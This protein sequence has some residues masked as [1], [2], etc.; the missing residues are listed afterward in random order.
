MS[1]TWLVM[2]AML[3]PSVARAEPR[4]LALLVGIND[5]QAVTDLKGC[6]NDVEKMRSVLM[7]RFGFAPADIVLLKDAEASKAAILQTFRRHLIDKALTADTV[8]VFHYSGHGSRMTDTS[9]DEREDGMDET[10]V[11]QDSRQGSVLDITD[12]ELNVL[13]RDLTGRTRNVTVILDSC[14]SGSA[15]RGG[16]VARRVPDLVLPGPVAAPAARSGEGASEMR[17][18]GA[19][20]VLISGSAPQELSNEFYKNGQPQGA[21]TYYLTQALENLEGET[22][23]RDLFDLVAP[24]V[25][26]DFPSQHPQIEGARADT[27]LFGEQAV[28]S[29]PHYRV[30][31]PQDR[32]VIGG[33][34]IHGLT[35][36]STLDVYASTVRVFQAPNQPIASVELTRVDAF[37]S[38]AKVLPAGSTPPPVG[39]RAVLRAANLPPARLRVHY[40]KWQAD[41]PHACSGASAMLDDVRQKAAAKGVVEEVSTEAE[42]QIIVEEKGGQVRLLS[43]DLTEVSAPVAANASAVVDK[44]YGWAK[45]HALLALAN[46][47]TRLPVAIEVHH[48]GQAVTS[49]L[50][51]EQVD[52]TVRNGSTVPLYLTLLDLSTDGSVSVLAN[53]VGGAAHSPGASLQTPIQFH[54]PTGRTSVTDTLKVL[55]TTAPIDASVFEQ[56]AVRATALS[57]PPGPLALAFKEAFEGTRSASA[58]TQSEWVTVSAAPIQVGAARAVP[59]G[60]DA[61]AVHVAEGT[62]GLDDATR[63]AFGDCAATPTDCWEPEALG[64]PGTF[65]F[66]PRG[67]R[68]AEAGVPSVGE[69]WEAAYQLR[70]KINAVRVEP[71]T[72]VDSTP[73]NEEE[74][75]GTRS[76]RSRPDKPRAAADSAWSLKHIGAEQAWKLLRDKGAADGEEAK[77]IIVGHPDTGYRKHP[78][79]WNADPAKT[80]ILADDGYDFLDRDN[81]ATDELDQGGFIPNPGHGTKSGS[82]IVSPKGRQMAGEPA[83]QFVSGVA[84]GARLVPLR[85]HRSVV[86]FKTGNLAKA[87]AAAAGDDRSLVKKQADVISIS[88][89]GLPGWALWKAVRLAR[90]KGVIVVAAAGNEVKTV[91]WPAR[92]KEVVAV[93]ASNVECGLWAG[94][95]HGGAVDITAPGESVWRAA[96]D[97]QG[98]DSIGMGQ[99]T[100][101]A[102]AT[103]AGVAALWLAYHRGDLDALKRD[104]K[105][106][107]AFMDALKWKPWRPDDPQSAPSGVTCASHA[108]WQP[109]KYGAGIVNAENVL[110]APLTGGSRGEEAPRSLEDLPLFES[111]FAEGMDLATVKRRYAQLFGRTDA[112]ATTAT[113]GELE[114]EIVNSYATNA[115]VAAALDAFVAAGT[116]A[117]ATAA[118]NALLGADISPTLRGALAAVPAVG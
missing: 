82:V 47:N 118:R 94:A 102:T 55:A 21:L 22:T 62:R 78:E 18:D 108:P 105:V 114:G 57:P 66:R 45:W 8:V 87:I 41:Q 9:G 29:A 49:V 106:T 4:R 48:N 95:S 88:M 16:G 38:Q 7:T 76:G 35:V 60:V 23:Y 36:G 51:E 96:M 110:K 6:V 97:P 80:T 26:A 58:V 98:I 72:E 71:L 81:D 91:V 68:S 52:I 15:T 103:V 40:C 112:D 116:P 107:D 73:W 69:A 46:Q 63:G 84:P 111:L 43:P 50:S 101:F 44:L 27:V 115:A 100:T 89:G 75:E 64:T 74:Q 42:A 56:D 54:L 34:A 99:G 28:T 70:R 20:Y 67:T 104:G 79:M 10:L 117:S 14:H 32:I 33:G 61:F 90:D 12:D 31:R 92:F 77:G 65:V 39:S 30:A 1:R 3:L 17:P 13:M 5:Y 37:T 109:E 2:V 59:A 25:A 53:P 86:H 113:L 83:T 11:A 24:R 93:S 19:S 85:V